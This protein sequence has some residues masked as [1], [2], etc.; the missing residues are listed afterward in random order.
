M[1]TKIRDNIQGLSH[2]VYVTSPLL[3][4]LR[5]LAGYLKAIWKSKWVTN[6]GT[7]HGELETK[8]RILLDAGGISLF[9]N[10]AIALLAAL[11]ALDLPVGSEVITT[12]FTFPATPHCITWNR[13]K[14]VFC[15]IHPESMTLDPKSIEKAVS[16]NTSAIL[17]VHVY[18]IPCD[19][20]KIQ[21]IADRHNL[22]IL[23]DA[24]HAFTTEVSG[25][26][27]SHF[28]HI[29]MFSFHATKLYNTIEGGCLAYSDPCYKNKI[30]Y[31]R[32]FGIKN[33]DEV[34][35]VGLNG[36]MNEIQA[37]IGLLN[38]N[39]FQ[40]EKEKRLRIRS[41][42]D[43]E[44]DQIEGI[45]IVKMPEGVTDSLQYYVIRINERL[46]GCSRNELYDRLKQFNVYSRKY[47]YPLC[48]EYEPYK[49]LPSSRPE[50]LPNANRIKNEVLCLPFYGDLGEK[51]ARQIVKIIKAIRN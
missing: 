27:I 14:P 30:Y 12:P 16:P 26:P 10:G 35:D 46:F 7:F 6:H 34:V 49:D 22:K 9:N 43:A 51:T 11:R 13:L 4:S 48:S 20:V 29:S 18:G 44:L 15:D 38:L 19:V 28:G 25:K 24:A 42:Y 17:G 2:P 40:K 47:F 21:Q 33:E 36:K 1:I 41:I 31:L 45:T 32:N 23:Y 37:A 8:L 5:D 50:Y 3:P 39:L